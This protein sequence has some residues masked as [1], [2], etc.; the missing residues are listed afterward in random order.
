MPTDNCDIKIGDQVKFKEG[1]Y[2]GWSGKVV[3]LCHVKEILIAI[4]KPDGDFPIIPQSGN[5]C[6]MTLGII[7]CAVRYLERY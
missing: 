4:L 2:P 7:P 1:Y 5:R 6:Q 3:G